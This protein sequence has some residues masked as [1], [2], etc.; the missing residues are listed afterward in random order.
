MVDALDRPDR[1]EALISVIVPVYNGQDYLE[2][3]VKSIENQTYKNLEIIIINDG[4]KDGT[5]DV[6]SALQEEYNNVRV[7]VT[8]DLGVSAARNAGL[9][10]AGGELVAFVDADDR[11]HPAMLRVLADGMARTKSDIVGCRFFMWSDEAQWEQGALGTVEAG[12]VTCDAGRYLREFLLNGNSRCWSKLYRMDVIGDT[13]FREGLT[14]GE[15]MLFVLSLLSRVDKIAEMDFQGYGY[16][17]N[18]QGAINRAFTL[19]YM[20]QITC[21]RLAREEVVRMDESLDA[22]VSALYIMGIML[23]AGKLA[24][25]SA[26]AREQ[27]EDCVDTCHREIKKIRAVPGARRELSA[28][29]RLKA[30]AFFLFPHGYLYMYH[31]WKRMSMGK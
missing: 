6:C 19:R 10:Q 31:F 12:T 4:S 25:L 16:Y 23:T 24:E 14:I 28:G 1:G 30:W 5:A 8:D 13:R 7:I 22:R 29:Y 20:D 26:T 27:Y 17:Q 18:P 11:L 15:D 9:D 21:W 3:C 2:S